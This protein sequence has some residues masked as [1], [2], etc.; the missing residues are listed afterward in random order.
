MA[1]IDGTEKQS[2]VIDAPMEKVV[3]FFADPSQL[4]VAMT[5]LERA[6]EVEPGTWTWVLQE[7]TEKGIRFQGRYTVRY[8]KKGDDCVEWSTVGEDN[9]RSRGVATFRQLGSKTELTYEETI[10][11]DLPVPKLAA[12]VFG[13]IVAREIRKGV[14]SFLQNCKTHLERQYGG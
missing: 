10:G 8:E 11:T 7:K 2:L 4:K 9:M 14:E 6:E 1:W 3:D 13:P 5:Q 12:K